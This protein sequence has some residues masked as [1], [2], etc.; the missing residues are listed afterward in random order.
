MKK[1]L[2]LLGTM[3]FILSFWLAAPFCYADSNWNYVCSNNDGSTN[4][5]LDI[6]SV[7]KDDAY[8]RF[9]RKGVHSETVD[10]EKEFV[11]YHEVHLANP[12]EVR[13][14]HIISYDDNGNELRNYKR[15]REW[16]SLRS[17][18]ILYAIANAAMHYVQ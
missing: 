8:L 6:S 10:G 13:V 17:G 9:W 18:S 11:S 2:Y 7:E 15:T 1:Y 12:L 14:L 3:A 5:Y 16:Q 4:Y